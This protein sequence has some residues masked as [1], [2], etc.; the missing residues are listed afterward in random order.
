MFKKL[1]TVIILLGAFILPLN[2]SHADG[3]FIGSANA[4]PIKDMQGD[5]ILLMDYGARNDGQPVYVGFAQRN[6]PTSTVA[7][8]I[9]YFTYDGDEQLTS[10]RTAYDSWDNRETATYL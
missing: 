9:Y 6:T 7:W 1:L 10:R 3:P 2:I 4:T 8:T 5:F